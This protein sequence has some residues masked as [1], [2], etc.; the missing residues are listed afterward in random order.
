MECPYCKQDTINFNKIY[1]WP[2]GAKECS[3]CGEHSKVNK[4]P[5]LS[6]L[7]IILGMVWI[8][9][10]I[11]YSN[12][13]LLIPLTIFCFGVEYLMDKKFRYLIKQS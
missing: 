7:S 3:A 9:V 2:F 4:N 5:F 12:L 13:H 8:G 10:P 1:C 11:I 6:S